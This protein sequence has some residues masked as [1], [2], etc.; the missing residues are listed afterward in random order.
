MHFIL[1]FLESIYTFHLGD[2]QFISSLHICNKSLPSLGGRAIYENIQSDIFK[3]YI[4]M[5]DD[6]FFIYNN[7]FERTEFLCTRTLSLIDLPNH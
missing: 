2:Y 3:N 7:L 6:T 4:Q 5:C 1:F